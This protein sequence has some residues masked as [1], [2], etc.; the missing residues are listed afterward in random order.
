MIGA[1]VW[2]RRTDRRT[3]GYQKT[4][5]S[6]DSLR[7]NAVTQSSTTRALRTTHVVVLSVDF[8]VR[9]KTYISGLCRCAPLAKGNACEA[10]PV[11]PLHSEDQAVIHVFPNY[12][13]TRVE[14]AFV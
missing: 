14:C 9:T 3:L 1:R 4:E 2:G 8:P 10:T 7:V 11:P 12:D 5:V 13:R 6:P